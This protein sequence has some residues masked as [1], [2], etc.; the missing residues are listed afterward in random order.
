MTIDWSQLS[1]TL[2]MA[3][4]LGAIVMLVKGAMRLGALEIKVET[5]WA[6]QMRRAVSETITTGLGQMKSPLIFTA[7]ARAALDPIR[8][9]LLDFWKR[10]PRGI[11][12]G[13][14][15][16][17]IEARF[18]DVLLRNVCIPCALSHGACLLLALDIAK[19]SGEL[20]L[21][22]AKARRAARSLG[23]FY[24]AKKSFLPPP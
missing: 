17:A 18:G 9:E 20:D 4:V 5:M 2:S 22:P 3:T 6:F 24:W 19:Q 13:E 12:D 21:T 15:L 7:A 23:G 14:A 10:L 8:G 1:L 11:S 16:L